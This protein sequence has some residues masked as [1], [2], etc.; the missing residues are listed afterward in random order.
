MVRLMHDQFHPEVDPQG[1]SDELLHNDG[2]YQISLIND[3]YEKRGDAYI[4]S[5]RFLDGINDFQRIYVGIPAFGARLDRWRPLETGGSS[6][7]FLDVKGSAL[8][9]EVKKVWLKHSEKAGYQVVSVEFNCAS[10]EMRTVSSTRY[11]PQD[12][13]IA[14][15]TSGL[16]SWHGVVPDSIGEK[17]LNGACSSN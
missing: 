14:S 15:P 12:D 10:R 2:H 17:L 16:D 7:Y 13:L 1:F 6:G 4:Q 3:V 9:G 8:N 11:T 5:G